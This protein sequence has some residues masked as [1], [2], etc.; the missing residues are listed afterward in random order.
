MSAPRRHTRPLPVVLPP[1][2]DELLSSWIGRHARFCGVSG[3]HF[4]RHYGLQAASPRA[5]DLHLT[6]PDRDVLSHLPRSDPRLIRRMTQ[7]RGRHGRSRLIATVRPMQVCRRCAAHHRG[8]PVTR[9]ARLRSWMEGWRIRC[10]VCGAA[11]EDA[12]PLV[13]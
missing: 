9:G 11:M 4:L 3:R 10:P 1:L 8:D 12:R 2:A 5:L 13:C 6:R 7:W